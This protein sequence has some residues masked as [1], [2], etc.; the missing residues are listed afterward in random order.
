MRLAQNRAVRHLKSVKKGLV[1][2][3]GMAE[4]KANNPHF[5]AGMSLLS[6]DRVLV[7]H[8]QRILL[9]ED[10][11]IW[12]RRE[13]AEFLSE[14]HR[15]VL[16]DNSSDSRLVAI[17]LETETVRPAGAEFIPLREFLTISQEDEFRVAGLGNQL[18][19]WIISHRYCGSCGAETEPHVIERALTCPVCAYTCYPRINPCVIVLVTDG[20][21]LLLARHARY[22]FKMYSCLAGFV[23]AG[24]TP[25]ETVERE[26]REEAGIEIG[27]IRYVKSQSWPFP[28]QLMLGFYA[29]YESGNLRPEP[30]EIAELKWF[31]PD[32]LPNTPSSN[33][34]VAG[35]LIQGHCERWR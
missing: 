26:V 4:H 19:N 35:Q 22:R 23:E 13:L 18:I 3:Q 7:Y 27:N 25:E 2:T 11:Y 32:Q 21:R 12:E 9:R 16:V 6:N 24:E 8:R 33:I 15:S 17:H 34:S 30:G 29:D 5:I 28:S 14:S 10:Q 31:T 1:A 20:E